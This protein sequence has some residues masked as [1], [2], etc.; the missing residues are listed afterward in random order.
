M[1][2]ADIITDRLY[3]PATSRNRQPIWDV[4]SAL[5]PCRRILEVASGS[6]EHLAFF[7]EKRPETEWIGSDPSPAHRLS[8]AAWNTGMEV[9]DLDVTSADWPLTAPVDGLIATNLLHISP[10]SAAVGLMS[11]AGRYVVEG[12]WLYLYGA[13]FRHDRVTAPS[14]I[15]FDQGLRS[16]NPEWGVRQLEEVVALAAEH[17]LALEKVVDMPANN[18]SVV[19]RC[20]AREPASPPGRVDM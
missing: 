18:Y 7:R 11:G 9:L 16:Q 19:F 5:M 4:L 3:F 14:N 2:R 15:S 20:G 10:W 17:G 8:I 12:G 1:A 6:G 13:Y